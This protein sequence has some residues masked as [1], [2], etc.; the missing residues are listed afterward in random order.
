MGK[1][2]IDIQQEEIDYR[3]ELRQKVIS[4]VK[5]TEEEKLWMAT[6]KEFSQIYGAP[7]LKTDVILLEN[8][9]DYQ[10]DVTFIQASHSEKIYP[11]FQAPCGIGKILTDVELT[12]YRGRKTTGK[13][14]KMLAAGINM[15]NPSFRFSYSSDCDVL[16]VG[17]FCE[18]YDQKLHIKTGGYSSGAD[19][20]YMLREDIGTNR[21]LYRCKSKYAEKFDSLAFIVEFTK[22]AMRTGDG[23]LS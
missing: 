17:F 18:Y 13:P 23:S 10:F 20:L 7:F 4:G 1:G 22:K 12:D 6:H 19:C 16:V 11:W 8:G 5:P 14:V 2:Y 15:Q 9:A 3:N 21:I